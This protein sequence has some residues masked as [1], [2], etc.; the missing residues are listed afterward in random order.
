[1]QRELIVT[2]DGSHTI[3]N[4]ELNVSY[5]STHGAIAESQ[6]VYINTG[7]KTIS[8]KQVSILDIG[9][10]SGL[11]A[12]LTL[13]HADHDHL[14]ILYEGV[15]LYPLDDVQVS[16]LNYLSVLREEGYREKFLSMHSCAWSTSHKISEN[17]QLIKFRE[18]IL[19]VQLYSTYDLVYFDAFAPSAQPL[20][21]TKELFAKIFAAMNNGAVLTTYSSKSIVR[22]ALTEAGFK[23]DKVPG[24][25]GK[26]E[27]VR[28]VKPT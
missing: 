22:R 8:K 20:L 5:H 15:E 18:D 17:F 12:I 3:F 11:N 16:A 2:A 26:R 7:L 27:I 4:E 24:P 1:M 25:Y 6:H 23:V 10:G 21:W 28:A 9:F 19:T 13:I 14:K